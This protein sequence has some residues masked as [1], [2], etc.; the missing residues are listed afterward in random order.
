[1]SKIPDRQN[2][3]QTRPHTFDPQG[4][5][6]TT[7]VPSCV[8]HLRKIWC[9]TPAKA[10]ESRQDYPEWVHALGR[11]IHDDRALHPEHGMKGVSAFNRVTS[12]CGYKLYI[13]RAVLRNLDRATLDS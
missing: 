5:I 13:D 1:M 9:G 8:I 4:A 3:C 6:K 12:S 11:S 10:N 2:G 7:A